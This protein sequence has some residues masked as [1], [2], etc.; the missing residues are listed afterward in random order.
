MRYLRFSHAVLAVFLWCAAAFAFTGICFSA[1][2]KAAVSLRETR[3]RM[4][5]SELRR[6]LQTKMDKGE[7]LPR[8]KESVGIFSQYKAMDDDILSVSVFD[9]PTGKILF[10]TDASRAGDAVY[11]RWYER[12]NLS[13]DM[14]FDKE[15]EQEALGAPIVNAF[16]EKTGCVVIEYKNQTYEDGR[17]KMMQAAFRRTGWLCFGGVLFCGVIYFFAALVRTRRFSFTDKTLSRRLFF[18]FLF[19]IVA[20]ALPTAAVS[21][22]GAFEKVLKDDITAK[23]KVVA[24]IV[25]F[26][27]TAAIDNGMP[28]KSLQSVEPY[29]DEIRRQNPEILFI[30]VTDKSGRVLYE[31]GSA[32]QAF[33]SDSSTGKVSLR[34]GFLNTAE[35]VRSGSKTGGWVQIGVMERF[36]RD[37]VF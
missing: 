23:A 6:I 37:Q 20:A 8:L 27:I 1:Y 11:A 7:S 31:A 2:D 35:P 9:F 33:E 17:K 19:L 5:L 18:V 13:D 34:E 22:Y 26:R 4:T 21:T 24:G 36:V 28:F 10:G 32:V 30:L 12:C 29:L 15:S 25:G 3:S 16:G 14:F